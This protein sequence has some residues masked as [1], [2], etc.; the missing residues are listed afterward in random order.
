MR[1]LLLLCVLVVAVHGQKISKENKSAMM[2]AMI[3]SMDMRAESLRLRLSQSG[4][5]MTSV[6]FQYLQY[7]NRRRL[8][9]YCMTYA[10]YSAFIL[11]HRRSKLNARNFAKLGRLVAYRNRV[12]MLWRYYTYLIYRH[13]K[14]TTITKK[15]LKLV[16]R[17]P[18][19]FHCV[20]TP[21]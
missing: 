17:D 2:V 11:T 14:K 9:R 7:L 4:I 20:D 10:K 5:K 6:E 13:G 18:A 8:L 3:K 16:K 1:S 15:M 21:Y 12:L 19:T